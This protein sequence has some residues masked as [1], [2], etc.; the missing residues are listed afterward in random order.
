MA[1][2]EWIRMIFAGE[3]KL[4]KLSQLKPVNVGNYPELSVKKLYTEFATRKT[5]EPYM[6]P[7]LMKGRQIDKVYFWNC[8]HTLHPEEL[9]S[10]MQYANA[11]RNSVSDQANQDDSI[12]LTNEMYEAMKKYP[13]IVSRIRQTLITNLINI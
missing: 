7:K 3:K 10:M 5:V 11:Q 4:L 8:V 9:E 13:W 1:S 2:K 12:R 6:P